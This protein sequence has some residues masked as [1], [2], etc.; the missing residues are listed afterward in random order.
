MTPG[1]DPRSITEMRIIVTGRVQGVGF[2]AF[3]VS[4][5][6]ALGLTGWVRNQPDGRSVEILAQGDSGSLTS[7][8]ARVSEGPSSAR[9]S[10]V[11]HSS[12]IGPQSF[13]EFVISH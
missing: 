9:V 2:R 12:R 3:T 7:F 4:A 1:R 8:L 5:A 6:H 13:S 10:H 11:E